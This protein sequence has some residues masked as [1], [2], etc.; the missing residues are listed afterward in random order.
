MSKFKTYDM[1]Q[2]GEY[3]C[4]YISPEHNEDSEGALV[5]L[6]AE[7]DAVKTSGWTQEDLDNHFTYVGSL[8][9]PFADLEQR[10]LKANEDL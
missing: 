9:V 10:V 6:S 7:P 5:W 1:F 2:D 8:E 3:V 4:F